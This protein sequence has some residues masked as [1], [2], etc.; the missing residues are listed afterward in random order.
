MPD[1]H[2]GA[3]KENYKWKASSIIVTLMIC[4]LSVY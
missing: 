1:E 2:Y 3:V 4:L